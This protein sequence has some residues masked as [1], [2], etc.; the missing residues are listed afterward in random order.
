MNIISYG[1]RA[2]PLI[3]MLVWLRLRRQQPRKARFFRLAVGGAALLRWLSKALVRRHRPSLAQRLGWGETSSFPSG[4]STDCLALVLALVAVTRQSYW[5]APIRLF[6]MAMALLM[7]MSRIIRNRHYP[8]DVLAGWGLAL[9]WVQQIRVVLLAVGV[10]TSVA[11]SKTAWEAHE[12]LGLTQAAQ[13]NNV[14]LTLR[15]APAQVGDNEWAVDVTDNRPGAQAAPAKVILRFDM[16]DMEMEP[17]RIDTATHD[18][19]RYTA[20][21]SYTSMGGRWNVEVVL[22]RAGFDDVTHTFQ[23]DIVRSPEAA[24][25]P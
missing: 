9:V 12:R 21:G 15:V 3:D 7:G 6:G 14:D 2:V 5:Q 25:A 16:I 23:L 11:P 19:Q 22:R 24:L 4:H 10:M 13:E 17:L 8:S 20:R 18:K 1:E